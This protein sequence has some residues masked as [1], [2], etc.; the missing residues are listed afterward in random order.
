MIGCPLREAYPIVPLADRHGVAIGF[1]R[2]GEFGHFGI[3]VDRTSI[4]D[5]DHLAHDFQVSIE[6]LLARVP[7]DTTVPS[8]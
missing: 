7:A 6:E 8:V 5:A 4:P 1:T 2:V 3:Y